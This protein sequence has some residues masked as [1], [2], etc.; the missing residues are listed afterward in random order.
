MVRVSWTSKRIV[1]RRMSRRRLLR[2][3]ALGSSMSVLAVACGAPAEP[4]P[5]SKAA[6][7]APP[8][9]KATLL[10]TT[11]P[12]TAKAAAPAAAQPA[13]P[14]SQAD[15]QQVVAEAK[16]EGKVVVNTFPGDG[17]ARALRAFSQAY[18]EVKLEQTSL[19]SQDF[20]PRITQERQ[21]G[22][23]TWDI[24][25]IPTSTALQVLRPAGVWDP[26]RPAIMLPEVK[27]DKVWRDG[28]EAGFLDKD[29]QLCYAFVLNRSS[30]VCINTTQVDE[31]ELKS[32]KDLFAPKWKGKL[33]LAD[34]RTMGDTFWPMT[35]ARLQVGDDL[36]K[37]LFVDQE[38]TLSR[39]VRQITEFM[40]RGKHPIAIGVSLPVLQDFQRQGLGQELKYVTLPE[41]DYQSSGQGVVW[42][43]NRAPHP[44]A[45]KLFINWL[46]TKDGQAV[47]AK[48][49]EVNSRYAGIEPGNPNTVMPP[50]LKLPQIDVEETL[51]EIIKTQDIAKQVI[52]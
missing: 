45:A 1:E 30:T 8:A 27:D 18:P 41:V 15:W 3:M 44:N 51:P 21:A 17:Y 25:L 16:K 22:V 42:L 36:I 47:W 19:H 50:G 5:E 40:V 24:A 34:V 9:A 26:V 35:I 7:V 14:T 29:K 52:K 20:S 28:F 39:D 13:A 46:L 33:L 43:V 6:P 48:E 11:P 4:K 2:L 38:A 31:G 12:A 10:P 37:Q 32:I 49:L 23:F